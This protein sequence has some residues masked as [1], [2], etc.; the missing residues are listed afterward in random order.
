MSHRNSFQELRRLPET[1]T[2]AAETLRVLVRACRP[3]RGSDPVRCAEQFDAVM[4]LLERDPSLRTKLQEA[5]VQ[6][7]QTSQQVSLYAEVD[8]PPERGITSEA[9]RRIA[10]SILPMLVN[11]QR[12]RDVLLEVFDQRTDAEWVSAVDDALWLNLAHMLLPAHTLPDASATR[13]PHQLEEMLDAIQILSLRIAA[14]GLD[15]ELGQLDPSLLDNESAFTAQQ[16]ECLRWLKHYRRQWLALNS[17]PAAEA[18]L[19]PTPDA[20]HLL[21]LWDQCSALVDKLHRRASREGTSMHLSQ[22]LHGLRQRLRRL[23]NLQ[24]VVMLHLH[25]PAADVVL[26]EVHI[27]LFKTLLEDQSG[28]NSVRHLVRSVGQTLALRVTDN[29]ARSGE[30]YITETR[31]E[32]MA[33]FRSAF[34]S[35]LIIALMTLDKMSILGHHLPPLTEAVLVCLNYGL[36]FV[37]IHMLGGTVATKQ[38]A[39][40]AA[41]IASALSNTA[42][43]KKMSDLAALIARTVRSQI[44]A[45]IGN[46]GLAIP[47]AAAISYLLLYFTGSMPSNASDSQYLLE[48]SH[49]FLSGALI[50][51]A[52][53]GACLFFSGLI[54]GYYDNLNAYN[55][56]PDRIRQWGRKHPR[57]PAAA[58]EKF[59][60][61]ID[62]HLGALMGN[63]LFGFMLGGVSS[64]G[65]MTGLPLDIRHVAFSSA[66]LGFAWAGYE[67][68]PPWALFAWASLGVTLIG[69]TNLLVSFFLALW[70]AFK[71]RRLRPKHYKNLLQAL[72]QLWREDAKVF[73]L[74][75]KN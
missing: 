32:Y 48:S 66:G 40:T 71:T 3:T 28:R 49:P 36:G 22:L 20:K 74:P 69:L 4:K 47:C 41:A 10:H 44:A 38:P 73:F 39:M 19:E 26:N 27:Q 35:G 16:I 63:L 37:L 7:L 34:G 30:H 14:Y 72:R 52:I 8:T 25:P 21:V 45:I 50:F 54:S 15:D 33:L 23:E 13:L 65:H 17:L 46:V 60:A 1:D 18:E 43:D 31:S 42:N 58:I 5:L 51:A 29:A 24:Q 67:M 75:P 6:L 12:L 11:P 56:I 2:S 59:A 64:L 55:R 61:Y 9:A 57:L 68:S 62:E 53:A 70:L